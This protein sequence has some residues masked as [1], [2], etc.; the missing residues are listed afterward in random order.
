[1]ASAAHRCAVE[2]RLHITDLDDLRA[3]KGK[4]YL[5]V[6]QGL[7]RFGEAGTWFEC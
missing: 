5:S 6:A 7:N 4:Q 2:H 3:W 1:M